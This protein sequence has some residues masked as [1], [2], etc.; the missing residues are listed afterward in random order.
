MQLDHFLRTT[1]TSPWADQLCALIAPM[2][3]PDQSTAHRRC[4]AHG[5]DSEAAALALLDAEHP[6]LADFLFARHPLVRSALSISRKLELLPPAAHAAA[7]RA[8]FAQDPHTWTLPLDDH[9]ACSRLIT[10]IPQHG[11]VTHVVLT[12]STTAE[13]PQCDVAAEGDGSII[14][15]IRSAFSAA[16]H[17]IAEAPANSAA[18]AALDGSQLCAAA[19]CAQLL[20]LPQLRT[21]T[22]TEHNPGLVSV[23]SGALVGS[24]AAAALITVTRL[25]FGPDVAAQACLQAH[26][27]TPDDQD[28]GSPPEYS[29]TQPVH[30]LSP[31]AALPRLQHLDLRMLQPQPGGWWR[32]GVLPLNALT[33]LTYLDISGSA[34]G[35]ALSEQADLQPS[36]MTTLGLLTALVHLGVGCCRIHRM[37]VQTLCQ[38]LEQMPNLASLNVS[39]SDVKYALTLPGALVSYPQRLAV[40][41]PQLTALDMSHC[42]LGGLP[43]TEVRQF[44]AAF[45]RLVRLDMRVRSLMVPRARH[46]Y[47]GCDALRPLPLAATLEHLELRGVAS[48]V[49]IAEHLTVLR[50]LTHLGMARLF[51]VPLPSLADAGENPLTAFA[52]RMC[53]ALAKMHSLRSFDFSRNYLADFRARLLESHLCRLPALACLRLGRN[54][55]NVGV[56]LSVAQMTQLTLLEIDDTGLT[57]AA[58]WLQTAAALRMLVNL[59]DLDLS[60]NPIDDAVPPTLFMALAR[61]SALTRLSMSHMTRLTLEHEGIVPCSAHRLVPVLSELTQLEVLRLG[62]NCLGEAGLTL[63]APAFALLSR[64]RGL[65]LAGDDSIGWRAL[66]ALQ[67][68]LRSLLALRQVDLR[69]CAVTLSDVA[70]LDLIARPQVLVGPV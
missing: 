57:R 30:N 52:E 35:S 63:L 29:A 16:S 47:I 31:L 9:A 17:A 5:P 6:D 19:N 3:D 45:T 38:A 53:P 50:R 69:G 26:S 1:G 62:A 27:S 65:S 28:D 64:V 44:L 15:R 66:G 68:G 33:Q 12:R 14:Q 43:T 48:A 13:A 70:T 60:H 10:L 59:R 36:L 40:V 41:A 37:G 20:S 7:C 46:E 42:G 25:D 54:Q 23:L 4:S 55:R 39:H 2:P 8:S 24:Q 21:I 61:L 11:S 56:G 32:S 51:C 34:F 22:F 49:S 58:G 67:R 18:L